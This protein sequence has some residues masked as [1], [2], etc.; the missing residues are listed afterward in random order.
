MRE[1]AEGDEASGVRQTRTYQMT[2]NLS[3]LSHRVR[4]ALYLEGLQNPALFLEKGK[5]FP[6]CILSLAPIPEVVIGIK[7]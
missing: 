6:M 1:E 3:A 7:L 4:M 2:V 5:C